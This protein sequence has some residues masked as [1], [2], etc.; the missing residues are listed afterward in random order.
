MKSIRATLAGLVLIVLAMAIVIIEYASWVATDKATEC[1]R[2]L[3]GYA[4]GTMVPI[5]EDASIEIGA[6]VLLYGLPLED[7]Q[8]SGG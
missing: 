2:L 3:H 7:T 4:D 6:C 1:S 5:T 8:A